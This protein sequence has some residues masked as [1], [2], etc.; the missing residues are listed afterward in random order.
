VRIG[1]R[2]RIYVS[3]ARN[4]R[5]AAARLFRAGWAD[6][7][8]ELLWRRPRYP[9]EGRHAVRL[10]GATRTLQVWEPL[11]RH[12]LLGTGDEPWEGLGDR[13]GMP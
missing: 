12:P 9:V 11:V 8:L 6:G 5:A 10:S 4:P 7:Q 3:L 1:S 2:S 13:L